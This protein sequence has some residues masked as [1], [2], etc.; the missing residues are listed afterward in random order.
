MIE[1]TGVGNRVRTMRSGLLVNSM[2]D[3]IHATRAQVEPL[4][5]AREEIIRTAD[6]WQR[7][8]T[9][10]RPKAGCKM[11]SRVGLHELASKW[12]LRRCVEFSAFF[13]APAAN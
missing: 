5:P 10:S 12:I 6:S 9:M 4:V 8:S 2:Q 13:P 1:Q 7:G 3:H 11:R